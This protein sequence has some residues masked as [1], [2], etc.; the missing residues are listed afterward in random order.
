MPGG[1]AYLLLHQV[2]RQGSAVGEGRGR[3]ALLL[4]ALTAQALKV[5]GGPPMS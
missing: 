2:Q 4:A 1:P 5:E 3:G